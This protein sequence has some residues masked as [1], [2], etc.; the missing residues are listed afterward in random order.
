MPYSPVTVVGYNANPPEDDGSEVSTN[1]ITWAGIKGKLTDPLLTGIEDTQAA[2]DTAITTIEAT[3]GE[4][5]DFSLLTSWSGRADPGAGFAAAQR[6]FCPLG[7]GAGST[8]DL[9]IIAPGP[10]RILSFN[11]VLTTPPGVGTSR[12]FTLEKNGVATAGVLTYAGAESSL[13]THTFS[14]P[15]SLSTV[16][17]LRINSEVVGSPAVSQGHWYIIF[18]PGS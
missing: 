9:S 10:R 18:L 6:Y 14:P 11:L 4:V 12:T 13:K 17:S 15:L 5:T 2:V 7:L 8:G 1:E 3:I 16:D